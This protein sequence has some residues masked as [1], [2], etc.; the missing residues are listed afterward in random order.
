MKKLLSV[1]L[2]AICLSGLAYAS[3][4]QNKGYIS[5]NTE[6]TEELEPTVVKISF[7]IETKASNLNSAQEENKQAS[8]KAINAIK[9]LVDTSKGE[10]VTT[11]SYSINPEYNYKDGTRKL[12]GYIARN[13]LNVT[14]KDPNKAGK[15]VQAAL[16][17]GANVVNNVQFILDET[18]ESCN[19]LIQKASLEAKQRANKVAQSMATSINGIKHINA[20]CSSVQ[21]FSSNYRLMTK[22]NTYDGAVGAE[23]AIPIEAGKTQLRAFVNAEF[24][25]K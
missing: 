22:A 3:E 16:S 9:E 23:S 19:K 18:N 8:I 24:F 11:T 14:L 13:T 6:A 7:G 21:S 10:N 25:V 5:V 20:G 4:N 17:N 2:A 15:I 1:L 12:N